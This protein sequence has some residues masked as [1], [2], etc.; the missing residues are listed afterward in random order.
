MIQHDRTIGIDPDFISDDDDD[1]DWPCPSL[2]LARTHIC[3]LSLGHVGQHREESFGG[4]YHWWTE[5]SRKPTPTAAKAGA[6]TQG[7]AA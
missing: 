1:V 5:N 6:P 4:G 3:E 2:N 7:D